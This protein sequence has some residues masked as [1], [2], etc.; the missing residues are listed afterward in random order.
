[1]ILLQENM[2]LRFDEYNVD[3]KLGLARML[4][5]W[6]DSP[7]FSSILYDSKFVHL[8]L[9]AIFSVDQI[10]NK[11]SDKKKMQFVKGNRMFQ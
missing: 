2:K 4:I 9:D 6:Q 7:T 11:K 5:E 1:M 3:L 8:L 10:L